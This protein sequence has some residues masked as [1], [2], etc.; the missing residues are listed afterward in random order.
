VQPEVQPPLAVQPEARPPL[1]V[2]PGAL[3]VARLVAEALLPL[4]GS[5]R[6][7]LTGARKSEVRAEL[8]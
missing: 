1:A 3:E 2:Q 6:E 7:P 8:R 5:A 4:V